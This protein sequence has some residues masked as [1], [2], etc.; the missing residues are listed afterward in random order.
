MVDDAPA[1]TREALSDRRRRERVDDPLVEADEREVRLGH[2]EVL[3]VPMVRDERL[4]TSGRSAG[5]DAWEVEAVLRAV[6]WGGIGPAHLQVDAVAVEHRGFRIIGAGPVQRVEIEARRAALEQ[7]RGRDRLAEHDLG[8][9]ERQ[10]VIDELTEI[11]E[12]GRHL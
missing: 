5:A 10:V 6:G 1:R 9:V 3:V 2:G 12:P 11:G 7:L 4:P 8:L